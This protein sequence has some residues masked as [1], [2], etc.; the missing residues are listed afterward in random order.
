MTRQPDPL[1]WLETERR[2]PGGSRVEFGQQLDDIDRHLVAAGATVAE[3]V[4]PATHAFL[5]ADQHAADQVIAS[6]RDVDAR[7]QQLEEACYVVLA[8]QSPV[9]GDLRHIVGVLR[10]TADVQRSS[11]LLTHIARSLH[12]VHPPSMSDELRSTIRQF[13]TVTSEI[14]TSAVEAWRTHDALTATELS[15]RDDEADRLQKY[16]LTEIYTG[17]QSV[18]EAVSLALLAR[19]YERIADH[20]V[21][22]A[23]QVTYFVTGDVAPSDE[24]ADDGP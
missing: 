16:L 14:F 24:A 4:L 1:D 15:R 8:R 7:C 3:R 22:I 2:Q 23:R 9:A 5:E 13:G 10:S 17:R 11:Y 12:W 18:E 21:A 19:Y 20:G 6:S